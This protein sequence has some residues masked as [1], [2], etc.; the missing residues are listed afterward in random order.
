MAMKRKVLSLDEGHIF[1]LENELRH[2]DY[3]TMSELVRHVLTI[4][5]NEFLKE[6][7]HERGLAQNSETLKRDRDL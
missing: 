1:W 6:R 7:A 4:G 5:I 3:R 2:G